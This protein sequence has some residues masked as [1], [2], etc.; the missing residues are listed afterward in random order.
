MTERDVDP[1]AKVHL[2]LDEPSRPPL[3]DVGV[4][5][6]CIRDLCD[7]A[8]AYSTDNVSLVD[9]WPIPLFDRKPGDRLQ[10]WP[11][12]QVSRIASGSPISL[13]ICA[14]SIGTANLLARLCTIARDWKTKREH[15]RIMN[16][17]EAMINDALR[18][19]LAKYDF[20]VLPQHALEA[21][22]RI[23]ETLPKFSTIEVVV[24]GEDST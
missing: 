2:V 1:A 16:E 17:R 12:P 14:I 20:A 19:F 10:P 15:D 22:N 7:L 8:S 9:E 4:H 18:E 13:D 23:T 6:L 5:L 3:R 24:D 21:F 11:E